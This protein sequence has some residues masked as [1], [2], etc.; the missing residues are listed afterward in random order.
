MKGY[1]FM[2]EST[3]RPLHEHDDMAYDRLTGALEMANELRGEKGQPKIPVFTVRTLRAW[4]VTWAM[5]RENHPLSETEV[6]KLVGHVDFEMLR[7]H[8]F[9]L[10]MSSPSAQK[11]RKGAALGGCL[12]SAMYANDSD[13]GDGVA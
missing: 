3:G 12:L 4:F 8:Y 6:I 13:F 1:V 7:K 2:N 5:T 10:D 9:R 11:M